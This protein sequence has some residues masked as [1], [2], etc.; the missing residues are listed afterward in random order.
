MPAS[1]VRLTLQGLPR[2]GRLDAYLRACGR[3]RQLAIFVLLAPF[4]AAIDR[5]AALLIPSDWSLFV[6]FLLMG[7]SATA[8]LLGLGALIALVRTAPDSTLTF[9]DEGIRES[10]RGAPAIL[11]PWTWIVDVLDLPEHLTLY[12]EESMKTLA[13]R[14]SADRRHVLIAANHPDMPTLRHLLAS[15][16][17]FLTP[18]PPSRARA[19]LAAFFIGTSERSLKRRACH[20][21]YTTKHAASA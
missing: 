1:E 21:K 18:V 4:P 17:R 3:P 6:P 13:L 19:R 5:G 11:R 15:H 2:R 12:F 14:I 7:F 10:V 16:T 8:A 9:T 20:A